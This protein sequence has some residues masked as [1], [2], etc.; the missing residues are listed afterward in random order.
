MK[1]CF[2]NWFHND[3]ATLDED[4]KVESDITDAVKQARETLVY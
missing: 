1:Q 3:F 2:R 4:L